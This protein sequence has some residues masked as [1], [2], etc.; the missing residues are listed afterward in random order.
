ME[1]EFLVIS[2]SGKK[3]YIKERFWQMLFFNF[4]CWE[5][6]KVQ[7]IT[8]K[9]LFYLSPTFEKLGNLSK[10]L[11]FLYCQIFYF[12]INLII[13]K[14]T[15]S[16]VL[17]KRVYFHDV[18]TFR[19]NKLW[20]CMFVWKSIVCLSLLGWLGVSVYQ[21]SLGMACDSGV[22]RLFQSKNCW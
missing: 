4:F 9:Q 11:E 12:Q 2:Y 15:L 18:K 8:L 16:K 19:E 3:T 1:N 13:R 6:E 22:S 21:V 17:I 5:I 10:Q 20:N 7:W 14:S